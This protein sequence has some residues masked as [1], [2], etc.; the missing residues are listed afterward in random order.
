MA[1]LV[2]NLVK[3]AFAEIVRDGANIQIVPIDAGATTD[4]TFRDHDT[5]AA[6]IAAA[7]ERTTGGWNRKAISNGSITLTVDDTNDRV[8]VD[9]ADQTWPAV[10]AGAVTDLVVS[11][12]LGGADSADRPLSLHDF[13]ITP[14]GS[15]VT[16]T[17]AVF[18][19]AS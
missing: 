8:D 11:E 14:D 7:T 12:D 2:F 16:A 13:A 9:V 3:G 19:R 10:T 18:L 15:D 4:A 6:V 1:D 5:L 17:V